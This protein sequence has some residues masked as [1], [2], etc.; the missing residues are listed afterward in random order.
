MNTAF[1]S[2]WAVSI[3]LFFSIVVFSTGFSL[4]T[5]FSDQL[6]ENTQF[7]ASIRASLMSLDTSDME[8]VPAGQYGGKRPKRLQFRKLK[9]S[10]TRFAAFG[11]RTAAPPLR[12]SNRSSPIGTNA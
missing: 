10:A 6:E 4:A 2:L 11:K 9:P 7:D 12:I 5:V 8:A 3:L 1:V